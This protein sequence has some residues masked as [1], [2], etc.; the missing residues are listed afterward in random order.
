[1]KPAATSVLCGRCAQKSGVDKSVNEIN[2]DDR[3]MSGLREGKRRPPSSR[4]IETAPS[5]NASAPAAH[6]R[7]QK[8]ERLRQC[9]ALTPVTIANLG[10]E[11]SRPSHHDPNFTVRSV[12]TPRPKER[13]RRNCRYPKLQTS[14]SN[15]QE[16]LELFAGPSDK[17]S[18]IP[19]CPYCAIGCSLA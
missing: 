5:V 7:P 11:A 6:M 13:E 18:G 9:A 12:I 15:L 16:I 8:R 4:E 3:R 1:M 10:R 17:I 19:E 14:G 2:S